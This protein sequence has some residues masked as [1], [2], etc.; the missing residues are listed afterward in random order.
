MK[1]YQTFIS[2]TL[3][4]AVLHIPESPLTPYLPKVLVCPVNSIPSCWPHLPFLPT[5]TPVTHA[6]G[7]PKKNSCEHTARGWQGWKPIG[8]QICLSEQK[9]AW[10]L[11]IQLS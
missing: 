1:D 3:C 8:L 2:L 7:R 9:W 5:A 10:G 11:V 4:L 6:M